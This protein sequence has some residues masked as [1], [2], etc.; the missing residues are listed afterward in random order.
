MV[1]DKFPM[2]N[3]IIV[4]TCVFIIEGELMFPDYFWLKAEIQ[5]YF[6]SQEAFAKALGRSTSY[7]SKFLNG[8]LNFTA[9]DIRKA[10]ELLD[11]RQSEIGQ[12]FFPIS[13]YN[14]ISP[15]IARNE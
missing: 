7:V 10:S 13:G 4:R 1:Q 2:Y 8:G 5:K 11:I 14:Y 15:K 12:F 6:H 3:A 9:A